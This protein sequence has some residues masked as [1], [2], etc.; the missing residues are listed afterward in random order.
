MSLL[1]R[2]MR[3]EAEGVLSVSLVRPDR[4]PLPDWELGA[5][6]DVI[7]RPDL[8][9]Q[10]SL[11]SLPS[12]SSEWEVAV[13]LDPATTGG[14]KYVHEVLR[15]GMTVAVTGPRN[16]FPLVDAP[17]YLFIAGGIGITPLLPMVET[18]DQND[19]DWKLLYGGR[20]RASMAFLP[21]LA[22]F[23]DRV[24]VRPEDEFGLLDLRGAIEPT[25][26]DTAIYCCGPEPLIDAVVSLVDAMDRPA[27]HIERFKGHAAEFDTSGDTG[28]DVIDERTGERYHVEADKTILQALEE[29]GVWV[30]SSCTEGYCGAC[31]TEVVAGEPEHRDEYLSPEVRETNKTM[32]ICV[33]RAKSRELVLR[34]GF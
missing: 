11:C 28:F 21:E 4:C 13:L 29:H 23:G 10:Y 15:P 22:R 34:L 12:Q 32:M 9:R 24:T 5:H 33:G 20:H 30:P 31:E 2:S 14:S 3:W 27:A 25:P 16:N 18:L 6:V 7:L 1:V 19:A 26:P 8:V 17:H